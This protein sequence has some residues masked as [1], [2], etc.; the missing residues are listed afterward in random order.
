MKILLTGANGYVGTRL[1]PLLVKD[2]HEIYALVRS[3]SRIE[4]PEKFQSQLHILE[5]ELK[6]TASFRQMAKNIANG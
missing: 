6:Q 3:R 4:I 1:L 5:A 2:G